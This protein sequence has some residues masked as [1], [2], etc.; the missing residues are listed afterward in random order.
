LG[1]TVIE[2]EMLEDESEDDY[3]ISSILQH[4]YKKNNIYY[5]VKF[6]GYSNKDNQWIKSTDL[7]AEELINQ[8][9]ESQQQFE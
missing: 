9:W 1:D 5:L 6:T 2:D 8:Y 4:K 3:E 7:S